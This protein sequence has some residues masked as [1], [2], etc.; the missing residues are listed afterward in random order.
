MNLEMEKLVYY[1]L[2]RYVLIIWELAQAKQKLEAAQAT[3]PEANTYYLTLFAALQAAQSDKDKAQDL[4]NQAK[5]IQDKGGVVVPVVDQAGNVQGVVDGS[6]FPTDARVGDIVVVEGTKYRLNVDGSVSVVTETKGTNGSN[7][8]AVNMG[9]NQGNG[10]GTPVTVG[11]KTASNFDRKDGAKV[12]PNTGS[13][14]SSAMALGMVGLM[15]T[16][17]LV[18][19]RRRKN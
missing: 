16:L 14:D 10:Q 9:T 7:G 11:Y 18:K 2:L 8:N 4:A 6:N 13:Q 19:S 15:A 1:L 12:L 3:Y 5:D 17:A